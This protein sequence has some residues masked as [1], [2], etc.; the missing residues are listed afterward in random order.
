MEDA[1][2]DAEEVVVRVPSELGVGLLL[3]SIPT[4]AGRMTL[5]TVPAVQPRQKSL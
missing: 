5:S 1:R 4:M 3:G 2:P